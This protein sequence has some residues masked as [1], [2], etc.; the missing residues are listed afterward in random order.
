[1]EAGGW[2]RLQRESRAGQSGGGGGGGGGGGRGVM[3]L[4]LLDVG[5]LWQRIRPLQTSQA[6]CNKQDAR[7]H[8]STCSPGGPSWSAERPEATGGCWRKAEGIQGKNIIRPGFAASSRRG[9]LAQMW[10]WTSCARCW[11]RC[12][13][14][15]QIRTSGVLCHSFVQI[16]TSPALERHRQRQ[17]GPTVDKSPVHC[18]A[19]QTNTPPSTAN[20][21]LLI[22]PTCMY[23]G[24]GKKMEYPERTHADT[25]D[26][27]TPQT[28][29]PGQGIEP[30]TF[31]L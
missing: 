29:I 20:I 11:W 25:E 12:W 6:A 8:R 3:Q 18:S 27:Q 23:T 16:L 4:L 7:C 1:M 5:P 19:T 13:C 21:K 14:N 2:R 22:H 17:P 15:F 24:C 30:A 28:K 26:M 9:P 10:K 31:L